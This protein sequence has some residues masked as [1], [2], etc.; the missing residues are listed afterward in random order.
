[1][2]SLLSFLSPLLLASL[3]T[4]AA[5]ALRGQLF[6]NLAFRQRADQGL[7]WVYNFE[8]ERANSHFEQLRREFPKHPAPYFLLATNRWWQSYITRSPHWHDYIRTR[9]DTALMM[10][11]QLKGQQSGGLEYIFFEYMCH[12]FHTRLHILRREWWSGANTGRKALPYLKDCLRLAAESPEFYY[13]AGVYHYY[14]ATYPRQR[15]YIRPIM[16][17]FPDGNEAL[18]L[19]ELEKAAATPNFTQVEAL[20]YLGDIYLERGEYA[21]AAEIKQRLAQRYPRNTWFR[22]DYARGLVYAGRFDEAEAILNQMK[23]EAEKIPGHEQRIISSVESLYTTEVMV[24]IYHNL[25]FLQLQRRSRH[26]LAIQYFKKSNR[27]IALSG[28]QDDMYEAPNHYFMGICYDR[29]NLRL[30][31][32]EAFSRAADCQANEP[33]KEKARPCIGQPCGEW[34]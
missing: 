1:V 14:A 9:I 17:F 27:M 12:A 32:Q 21:L 6:Y 34:Q 31:A 16:V 23:A 33:V 7:D 26:D 28:A 18:G 2:K 5:P 22:V 29:L 30:Q 19:S 8:F 10:N 15:A 25:G 13:S 11:Q 3:L 4:L 20:Y 24:R